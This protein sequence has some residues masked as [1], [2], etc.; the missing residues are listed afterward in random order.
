MNLRNIIQPTEDSAV[1]WKRMFYARSVDYYMEVHGKTA[2]VA[3]CLAKNDV[4][5]AEK[6][7]AGVP[8]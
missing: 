4:R 1:Y 5:E 7:R 6:A 3:H 2:E 8:A